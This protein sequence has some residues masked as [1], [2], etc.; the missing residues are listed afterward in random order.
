MKICLIQIREEKKELEFERQAFLRS[1]SV[2]G[3]ELISV[4]FLANG[5]EDDITSFDALVIGGSHYGVAQNDSKSIVPKLDGLVRIV[6]TAL[7]AEMP[8]LGI[9][10]GHQLL[11]YVC[12]G[13]VSR[14][15]KKE[16]YGT[17]LMELA[18]DAKNDSLFSGLLNTFNAQCAHHD[19]VETMLP[20]AILLARSERCPVQAFRIGKNVYGIQFH[21]ERSK[22]DYEEITR[23]R[24][25]DHGTPA[26]AA[27]LAPSPEAEKLMRNFVKFV[28]S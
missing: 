8:V 7:E 17:Y 26:W 21:P 4:D 9:C 3:D 19:M 1:L 27:H 6:N 13:S 23:Y 2:G 22:E 15:D 18:P 16:E 24:F 12:G 11:A 25:K 14:D 28:K 10:F 20:K 5:F